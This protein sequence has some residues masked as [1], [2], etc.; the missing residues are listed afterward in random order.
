MVFWYYGFMAAKTPQYQNTTIPIIM[1]TVQEAEN[2]ILQ[3]KGNYRNEKIPLANTIG[4]VL[5]E[6]L[7]AD[8]DMPPYNRVTMDGIAI[9]YDTYLKGQRGFK[10]EGVAAAGSP[11]LSLIDKE[12]CVEVM[13]GSIMPMNADAIIRYEDLDIHDG[14]ANILIESVKRNQN[15]HTKGED[16]LK[17]DLV[18]KKNTIISPAEIGVAATIG[19]TYL[20]VAKLPKTVIISTGDELVRIDQKPL[21]HQ[22]RKSNV[23]RLQ[24]TLAHHNIEADTNHLNDDLD[25]IKVALSNLIKEYDV[26]VL[27]GGVSKGKF[28]FLPRALEAIGVKK[29]FH[30]ITQR[31]GKPFWFGKAKDGT[32]IFALPGNPV[33]SFLCTQRYF[34][35]WLK[36]SL[37]LPSPPQPMAKLAENYLFKPDL[38]YFLQVKVS[39]DE[40][41]RIWATPVTGNGSGDLAN[42]VE[43]DAFLELPR[44]RK[45]FRKGGVYPLF[46]Y[47]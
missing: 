5:K 26:L 22:I 16:R 12:K 11:Q 10:I 27:S 33:S 46:F 4:R 7:Y 42:L 45:F 17:G 8:R 31:P 43:A 24:A 21:P 18:V 38:T 14:Q 6:D 32:I 13:T 28:D 40:K 37:G 1:I 3:N 25:L 23:H 34:I 39:Y 19:K 44:G 2:L 35:P 47:R 9:H 36:A 29:L 30:K 20:D 15:I 41:G